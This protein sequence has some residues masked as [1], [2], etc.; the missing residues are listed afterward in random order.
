MDR[1]AG[2]INRRRNGCRQMVQVKEVLVQ[3]CTRSLRSSR[4]QEKGPWYRTTLTHIVGALGVTAAEPHRVQARQR[5]P[6]P[7]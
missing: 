1:T 6:Q 4:D 5:T 2:R 3:Y 7:P